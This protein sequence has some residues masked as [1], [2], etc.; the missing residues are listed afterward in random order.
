RRRQYAVLSALGFS[1]ALSLAPGVVL[2]IA[3]ALVGAIAGGVA[4]VIWVPRSFAMPSL[5]A[6]LGTV[7]PTMDWVVGAVVIAIAVAACVLGI[8]SRGWR[9]RRHPVVATL[10]EGAS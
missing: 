4:A 2:G 10:S 1:P 5:M 9:L 7:A 8:C 3:I 6:D